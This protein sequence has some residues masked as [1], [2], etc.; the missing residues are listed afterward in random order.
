MACRL[1][2]P[3]LTSP[4]SWPE[5]AKPSEPHADSGQSLGVEGECHELR[6][7]SCVGCAGAVRFGD[8]SATATPEAERLADEL[9]KRLGE[10]PLTAR[11]LA[12]E[13][14]A[15]ETPVALIGA[16]EDALARAA[17]ADEDDE[18]DRTLWGPSPGE[19]QLA[20]AQRVAYAALEDAM[21]DALSGALSRE[22]AARRLGVTPQAV[23]KRLAGGGLV[24]LR[25]GRVKW[26]PAWQFHEDG[27]L[28]GLEQVI[29]AYPGGALSLTSWATL[30]SADLD[31]R[32]PAQILARRDG[33]ARVLEA[34]SA[35]TPLAW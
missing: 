21:R 32:T 35:L 34:L 3:R 2:R 26:F 8:M 31:G 11:E 22:Q 15:G 29:A 33:L 25:R 24:A 10:S 17:A 12:A 20:D 23:S 5:I 18:L 28:P 27:V 16:L 4:L 14:V 7:V 30:T 1:R 6:C 19:T 9:V 13:V